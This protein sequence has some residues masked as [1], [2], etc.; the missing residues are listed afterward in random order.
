MSQNTTPNTSHFNCPNC[1]C[2]GIILIRLPCHCL[3]RNT[4]ILQED[5]LVTPVEQIISHPT[6]IQQNDYSY[7]PTHPVVNV[8]TPRAIS[9][10]TIS[11]NPYSYNQINHLIA[12]VC[13]TQVTSPG[14]HGNNGNCFNHG[15]GW[16]HTP[17]YN[18]GYGFTQNN[19][20]SLDTNVVPGYNI[21][22]AQNIPLARHENYGFNNQ[23]LPPL[24]EYNTGYGFVQHNNASSSTGIT[25]VPTNNTS[26]ESVQGSSSGIFDRFIDIDT[27]ANYFEGPSPY[28]SSC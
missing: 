17:E 9:T 19:T 18:L 22:R 25:T 2:T 11:Q 16:Q 13:P 10:A 15:Q 7:N 3:T 14:Q 4:P 20:D 5:Q 26:P 28:T 6:T 23:E 24:S 12:N 21:H 1:N 27:E 8:E